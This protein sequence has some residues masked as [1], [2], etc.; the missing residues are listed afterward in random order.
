MLSHTDCLFVIS[1]YISFTFNPKEGID[2][3]ALV[4]TDDPGE[5]LYLCL[6]THNLSKLL[7]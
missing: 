4:I 2:N 7:F 6:Y 5:V 3:P 1:P